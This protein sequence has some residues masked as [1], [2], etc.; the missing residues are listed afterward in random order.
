[1]VRWCGRSL[2]ALSLRYVSV[3]ESFFSV[4]VVSGFVR[5][6]LFTTGDCLLATTTTATTVPENGHDFRLTEATE[7]FG[8]VSD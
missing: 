8:V 4:P 1:M 7:C 5:D 3:T 6:G 2:L